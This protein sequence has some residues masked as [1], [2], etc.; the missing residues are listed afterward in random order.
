VFDP[1]DAKV[2]AAV[3]ETFGIGHV[4]AEPSP[5]QNFRLFVRRLPRM[6]EMTREVRSRMEEADDERQSPESDPDD[7]WPRE[8]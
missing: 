7:Y 5:P 6:I 4:W 1:W 8:E 3:K 2:A